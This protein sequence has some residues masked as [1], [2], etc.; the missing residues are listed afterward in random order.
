MRRTARSSKTSA[1]GFSLI[2]VLISL[3]IT[4]IV[5]SSV[6][7]LLMKGQRSFEREPEIAE[8]QQNARASLDAVARDLTTAGYRTPPNIAIQWADGGGTTPDEITI[9]YGDP[10]LPTVESLPCSEQGGGPCNTI[11]NSATL[12]IDS[13]SFEPP[14][15]DPELAYSDGTPLVIL[16]TEDCNGDGETG[17]VPFELTM[18]PEMVGGK[19]KLTHNPGQSFINLPQGFN[20]AVEPDCAIVGFFSIVQYRVNPLPPADNPTMERRD[21]G[22]GEDWIPLAANIEDFQLQYGVGS[23]ANWVDSPGP[24]DP[25]DPETWITRVNLSIRARSESTGLEGGTTVNAATPED[26]HIRKTYVT[27]MSLRNLLNATSQYYIMNP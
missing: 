14:Q 27:T 1:Q 13:D 2:E 25:D 17:V 26:T 8:L 21:V 22:A 6:F 18:D 9:I 15:S 19:L 3:T 23:A 11:G 24:T 20:D 7:S 12:F 5:M 10:L 4:L 16:E